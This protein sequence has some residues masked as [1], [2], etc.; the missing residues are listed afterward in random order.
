MGRIPTASW[1]ALTQPANTTSKART[2]TPTPAPTK[3]TSKIFAHP[4]GSPIL[5]TDPISRFL[6]VIKVIATA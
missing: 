4:V 1:S 2:C 3:L 6:S 5:T